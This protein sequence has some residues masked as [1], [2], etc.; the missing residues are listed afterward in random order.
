M[1]YAVI[2]LLTWHAVSLILTTY[3]VFIGSQ[4]FPPLNLRYKK[5]LLPKP[6]KFRI[7]QQPLTSQ[8]DRFLAVPKIRL[9]DDLV[10]LQLSDL[11]LSVAQA[12]KNLFVVLA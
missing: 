7:L 2:K 5:R 9:L 11:L 12:G 6:E 4:T 3:L 8:K 10:G 1:G